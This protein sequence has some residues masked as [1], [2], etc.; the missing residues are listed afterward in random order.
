MNYANLWQVFK[1]SLIIIFII[2][3]IFLPE[4]IMH[5]CINITRVWI[6]YAKYV[7]N[8]VNINL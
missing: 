7:N 1:N 4:N 8:T 5:I 6:R 2:I 3:I